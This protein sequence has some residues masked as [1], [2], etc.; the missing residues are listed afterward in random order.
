MEE[1]IYKRMYLRLFNAVTDAVAILE[2]AGECEA[3]ER[4]ILGQ[5]ET[6][7]MFIEDENT[8]VDSNR[9]KKTLTAD[10]F[11]DKILR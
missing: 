11:S 3:R 10:Q 9:P 4:L 7:R 6:E 8:G 1:R 2:K 5:R